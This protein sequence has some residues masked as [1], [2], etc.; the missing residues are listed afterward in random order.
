MAVDALNEV[1]NPAGD[2]WLANAGTVLKQRWWL[3]AVITLVALLAA[4]VYLRNANY[5]YTAELRVYAAPSTTGQATGSGSLGNLASLAGI[6]PVGA[7][8]ATPFR[9]YLEGIRAREVSER[10]ARDRD[11]MHDAFAPEWDAPT[12][13][14]RER[15]GIGGS[16]KHVVWNLLGLPLPAWH[17]PDAAKLQDFIANGVTVTQ[18][19][20]SPLVSI[21]MET[22]DPRFGVRFLTV[23]GTTVDQ[24]LREKQQERTRSNIDYLSERLR[25]VTLIEQRAALFNAL[26]DQE[27]QA[28]LANSLAPYAANPFGV[29]VASTN[30]TTPRQVPLLLAGL[31]GGLLAGVA[32]ALLLGPRR[33]KVAMIESA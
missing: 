10:L 7:E 19:L 24:Y 29:A 3:V 31:F 27:R 8:P 21:T 13:S 17:A 23:L 1:E 18:S 25:G 28:M 9:L 5:L 11:L 6:A 20:K 12:R 22:S 26:S 4:V 33:R 16:I 32:A 15:R 14:W 30:P 2:N